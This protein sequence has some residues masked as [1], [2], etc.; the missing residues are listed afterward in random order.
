MGVN[1]GVTGCRDANLKL[2]AVLE[3]SRYMKNS[4]YCL[5]TDFKGVFT[6][7]PLGLIIKTI[8]I[9]PICPILRKMWKK[10]AL[11]NQVRLIVNGQAFET[12]TI[13]KGIAQ[14]K[15]ISPLTFAVVKETVAKWIERECRGYEIAGI[16]VKG[17]DYMDDEVCIADTEEKIRKMTTIQ[18]QFAEWSEMRFGI[19]KVR[20]LGPRVRTRVGGRRKTR[21]L[22]PVWRGNPAT[23][24]VRS[25]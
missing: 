23:R 3:D 4:L 2:T 16:E 1:P 22:Q 6:S 17:M 8:D 24:G 10:T 7:L 11:G 25:L 12:I 18:S 21:R 5:F 15:T 20:I 9:L 13:T 14:G 19:H